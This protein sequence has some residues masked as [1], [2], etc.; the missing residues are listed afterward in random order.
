MNQQT[1][2]PQV[3]NVM[4]TLIDEENPDDQID[5]LVELDEMEGPAFM[6]DDGSVVEPPA[7]ITRTNARSLYGLLPGEL[8]SEAI[9]RVKAQQG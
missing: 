4:I 7:F 6:E 8:V 9:A 1:T 3:A 2:A 5:G